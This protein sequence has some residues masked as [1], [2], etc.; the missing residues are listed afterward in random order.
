MSRSNRS[1]QVDSVGWKVIVFS[2]VLGSIVGGASTFISSYLLDQHQQDLEEKNVAQAIFIDVSQTSF[3]LNASLAKYNAGQQYSRNGKNDSTFI[4][5]YPN[6]YY[7][8]NGLYFVHS[9]EISKFNSNLST[10]IF[11]YYNTVLFLENERQYIVSRGSSRSEWDN[12]SDV[13][14]A[15]MYFYTEILPDQIIGTIQLG[16]K[17]RKD[18]KDEY[19]LN[20]DLSPFYEQYIIGDVKSISYVK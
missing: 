19:N 3:Y 5:Y 8:D 17:I 10:E 13:E 1:N 18:L 9:S 2:A 12:L 15:H 11:Q 6:P 16:E 20:T 14:K 4:F 7:R